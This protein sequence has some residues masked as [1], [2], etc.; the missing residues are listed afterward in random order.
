MRGS[1][2]TL[3]RE[4][5]AGIAVPLLVAVGAKDPHR[6]LGRGAGGLIPGAR[7]LPIPERDHMTAVG[8][9]AYK[10]GV[11]EFLTQRALGTK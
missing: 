1:R 5:V 9:R 4:Q 8:D 7:A 3:S 11:L 2:Q 6:R 10:A